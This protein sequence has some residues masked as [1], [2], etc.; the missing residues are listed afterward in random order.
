MSFSC[1][2]HK[3]FLLLY[4]QLLFVKVCLCIHN[5]QCLL[6]FIIQYV[7]WS[8]CYCNFIGFCGFF[9]CMPNISILPFLGFFLFVISSFSSI[10]ICHFLCVFLVFI[11]AGSSFRSIKV[12]FFFCCCLWFYCFCL[13]FSCLL[14]ISIIYCLLSLFGVHVVF[15][16]FFIWLTQLI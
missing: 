9:L 2:V 15:C 14:L 7:C 5:L 12:L 16:L 4:L 10:I 1:N 6:S 13:N 11:V 8:F 3:F